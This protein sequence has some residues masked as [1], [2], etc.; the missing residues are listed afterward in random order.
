VYFP[1]NPLYDHVASVNGTAEYTVGTQEARNASALAL[2]RKWYPTAGVGTTPISINLLWGSPG[3]TRRASEAALIISAEAAVGFKVIAPATAGW[4]G[5]LTS[6]QYDAHFFIFDQTANPQDGQI[7]GT[8][9]ATG[10]S[11]YT[12]VNDPAIE[13]ACIALQAGTLPIATVNALRL[14]V[15]QAVSKDAFFLGIFQNPQVTAYKS[16]LSGVTAA[17]LSPSLFWNFWSWHF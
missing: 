5:K 9:Q 14:Q 8:F 6:S 3:N 16:Q 11:N 17:P 2:V 15:E 1:G 7:C 10:G 13:K 12:G 4:G